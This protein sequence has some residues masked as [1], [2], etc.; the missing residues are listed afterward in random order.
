MNGVFLDTE[1]PMQ[2]ARGRS[3]REQR[4]E[5]EQALRRADVVA[6][7]S[8]VFA[9]KGFGDA[10]MGEIAARAEVSTASLYAMFAGKDEL[11]GEV[12]A[13]AAA[14]VRDAVRA[15][16]EAL[17][18]PRERLLGVIDALFHFWE[19]EQP[20]LRLYVRGTH[21]LPWRIREAMGEEVHRLFQ[22]FTAWLEALAG[23]AQRAG[24][25]AGIAP[26]TFALALVGTVST[27][28]THWLETTPERPLTGAV[29]P[30]RALFER[31]V[32]TRSLP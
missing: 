17:E 25:L 9:E 30:V 15:A 20:L 4:R 22:E 11:Y 13:T 6:A 14:S 12:L 16:V 28:S 3:L 1:P 32:G 31:L 21:G 29:A 27:V 23:D 2:E 10:Q 7:A 19:R 26:A 8:A 18:D 5:R 24:Y